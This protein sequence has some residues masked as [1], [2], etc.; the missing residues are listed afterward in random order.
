[1]DGY[2]RVSKARTAGLSH[3]PAV[4]IDRGIEPKEIKT[5]KEE[6]IDGVLHRYCNTCEEPKPLNADY[7]R[8]TETKRGDTY[9]SDCLAC[10][11]GQT[12]LH[13]R[14]R[15]AS[16]P[17]YQAREVTRNQEPEKRESQ[18]VRYKERV[19]TEP[20]YLANKNQQRKD[21]EA[22]YPLKHRY[23]RWKDGLWKKHKLTPEEFYN[24]LLEQDNYCDI[25][26]RKYQEVWEGASEEYLDSRW[27]VF[28][29][30]HDHKT[31]SLRS[32]LCF[33]CNTGL[34][35]FDD[36]IQLMQNAIE[37]LK[38]PSRAPSEITNLDLEDPDGRFA[39]PHWDPQSWEE[40]FRARK[41]KKE[42]RFTTSKNRNLKK[43]YGITIGQYEWLLSKQQGV[44]WICNRPEQ[45]KKSE[46]QKHP[47]TLSV[48]HDEVTGRIR[49][50]LCFNHNRGIG[51]FMHR[52]ETV[53]A[54]IEYIE[55]WNKII[56]Q[57]TGYIGE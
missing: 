30:D 8:P 43:L 36:D 29:V 13:N 46:K 38:L 5:P 3:L 7:F 6:M 22:K 18:Q 27:A 4:N 10:V 14:G 51:Q 25:C 44:C 24:M 17:E 55:R 56:C 12:N 42:E 57:S 47:R 28:H 26:L 53:S 21:R 41:N 16:D 1:M 23:K 32:L 54:A 33:N 20:G 48:N 39:I 35:G 40:E 9:R 31:D 11:R 49:G 37:Y 52:T 50:L 2:H 45:S 19:N 34:G 15:Y